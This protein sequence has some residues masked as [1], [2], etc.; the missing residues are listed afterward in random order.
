MWIY[1]Y[2]L[3]A[4]F[5]RNCPTK[6]VHTLKGKKEIQRSTLFGAI[7]TTKLTIDVIKGRIVVVI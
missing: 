2:V 4:S 3:G 7:N 1:G 6:Y 5:S